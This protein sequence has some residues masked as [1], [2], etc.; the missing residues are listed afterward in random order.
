MYMAIPT[1]RYDKMVENA[2]RSVVREAL[3]VTAEYGLPGAHHF[4]VTFRT[5]YPGVE[6]PD[7]LHAQYPLDMT[8][9]LEHQF[10]GLEVDDIR[11][12]VT[13]SFRNQTHRLVIP[14]A[15]I[16]AFADPSVKFGLEFRSEEGGDDISALDEHM[17]SDVAED[18]EPSEEEAKPTTGE[19][20]KLDLFRKK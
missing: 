3:T 1:L 12:S 4:Y 20:V 19:V 10:W 16:T 11:F 13:L 9:V 5:D 6:M 8:I 18:E 7:F 17:E 15:A 2:L 14:L